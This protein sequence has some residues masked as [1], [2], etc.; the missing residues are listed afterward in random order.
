VTPSQCSNRFQKTIDPSLK[1]VNWTP[2]EDAR[3]R[4]AV[5]A[6]GSSW[7][8]IAAVLP[9]RHNDQCRD[10]WTEQVNPAVN[11]NKWTD[12]EDGM[13]LDY[14]HKHENASWKETAEHVGNGRTENMVNHHLIYIYFHGYRN[15]VLLVSHSL[16]RVAEG[17]QI[18]SGDVRGG[19]STPV[20]P[21]I[22]FLGTATA[23]KG[24]EEVET[25]GR[26][27]AECWC[28]HCQCSSLRSTDKKETKSSSFKAR[29]KYV[30]NL[31]Y[32]NALMLTLFSLIEVGQSI[33]R[34]DSVMNSFPR[35]A[36]VPAPST[37]TNPQE[38]R[39]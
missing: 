26:R 22:E 32:I 12:Q 19:L 27:D 24:E 30:M 20:W 10:R 23:E 5:A 4:V 17:V 11:K 2:E 6:Y 13:L 37:P 28:Q 33:L 25:T 29:I 21:G 18:R 38:S 34:F 9:G 3:L 15:I 14:T 31:K 7:I 36:T 35:R 1:R 39:S 8:H 16:C